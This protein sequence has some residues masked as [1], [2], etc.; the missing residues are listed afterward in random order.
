M[1]CCIETWMNKHWKG[2][3]VLAIVHFSECALCSSDVNLVTLTFFYVKT[4]SFGSCQPF[5]NIFESNR[6]FSSQLT[7]SLICSRRYGVDHS[8]I[9]IVAHFLIKYCCVS[10]RDLTEEFQTQNCDRKWQWRSCW[11]QQQTGGGGSINVWVHAEKMWGQWSRETSEMRTVSEKVP[12]PA[13]RA[14]V[15]AQR[16]YSSTS[17]VHNNNLIMLKYMSYQKCIFI[18]IVFHFSLSCN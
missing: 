13:A 11:K 4:E 17:E 10:W 7:K 5:E 2:V 8:V 1:G 14:V 18:I 16:M 3:F 15:Q 12:D 9:S 6:L